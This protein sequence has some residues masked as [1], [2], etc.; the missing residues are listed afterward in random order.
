MRQKLFSL[1]FGIAIC[2]LPA[3]AQRVIA[4]VPVG[5][6]P[7]GMALNPVT[8]KV[9]VVNQCVNLSCPNGSV[10]VIDEDTLA[11]ATVAVGDQNGYET[12][13]AVNTTTNK[14]YVVNTCG[15]DPYCASNG[16]L[17][18]IDGAT[19]ATTTVPLGDR[20][21]ALAINEVTNTIFVV[22]ACGYN[23][24]ASFQ[25]LTILD[26]ATLSQTTIGTGYGF[27]DEAPSV[28]V[29]PV[30]NKVFV[31]NPCATDRNCPHGN[32]VM[33]DPVTLS[34]TAV[35]VGAFPSAVVVNSATN[36][37]YVANGDPDNGGRSLTVIDGATLST[38]TVL[39]ESTP[40]RLAINQTTNK[41]YVVCAGIY[42]NG[43]LA[44]ID[45]VTLAAYFYTLPSEPTGLAINST[46]NKIY[47][48]SAVNYY[49][50]NGYLT[51]V[52]GSNLSMVN[53]TV[54]PT[55]VD[56]AI[57]ATNNRIYT[58]NACASLSYCGSGVPGSVTV[59][60]GTPPQA[61]QFI[62]VSP[63]RVVDT[64]NPDGMFGGPPIDGGSY[65]DFPI[66]LG[67]CSIPSIAT[68]YALNV[69]VVPHSTL[70]YLTIWPSNQP[71]PLVST[72]NS[73]DGR[74]KSTAA[75]VGASSSGA[76]RVFVSD[77]AD[78]VLD[79]SGYFVALPNPDALA[80]YPL[81]PCRI[82]DTRN[83]IG[84]LGGPML[85]AGQQRDFPILQA[86]GCN[87]PS[88][89]Q[90]YSL[91]LTVVP[92]NTLGYLTVWPSGQPQPGVSNL[93][94][95]TG[96]IVANA[97]IVPAGANGDI[98]AYATD[99][100]DFI[101][102]INGYFAPPGTNGLSFYAPPPCRVVDTR[103]QWPG[104]FSGA[105]TF[106]VVSTGCS[107][108]SL[109]QAFVLNATVLPTN[110]LE[111]LTLWPDGEPQPLVSTLNAVDRAVTSNLAIVPSVD[112]SVDAFVSGR[113]YLILDI[114]GYFAP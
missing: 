38:S 32:V 56:A 80:F 81:T 60:D 103:T 102:D 51:V 88:A 57:D 78:V 61:W 40:V 28:A 100:T 87:I 30:T 12:P 35:Q 114:S 33:I 73:W 106:G 68:A 112:G 99:N 90:A 95:Y 84:S 39:F 77:T 98:N 70:D 76:V 69:T 7:W 113:T 26:G 10:S 14:I 111:Y 101:I 46:T 96:T 104:A 62:P 47:V 3:S 17:T 67:A 43:Q 31:V 91:N 36:K 5:Q 72:M 82:A 20:P 107:A 24:C 4:T 50:S 6:G 45:G 79:I 49:S 58:E 22:N 53:V 65:R 21:E 52:D 34:N 71:Q 2:A 44:V 1:L 48:T 89:A 11:T 16:T 93:N 19:L 13:I 75:I 42:G 23:D 85:Q 59:V 86:A 108:P 15:N 97:A 41:I 25:T 83:P 18:V 105:N 37:I 94:D 110:P 54:G 109:A 8:H 27:Y 63:C 92:Q 9:Y 74:I 66:P 29:N 55:P 64:R